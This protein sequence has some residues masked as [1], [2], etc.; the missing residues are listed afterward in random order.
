VVI[1]DVA[2]MRFDDGR[3]VPAGS[4]MNVVRHVRAMGIEPLLLTRIG[5]DAGGRQVLDALSRLGADASGVQVDQSNPTWTGPGG[6]GRP[7]TPDRAWDHLDPHEASRAIETATP[8]LAF[9][10]TTAASSDGSR[11]A[12]REIRNTTGVPFFVDVNLDLPWMHPRDLGPV[13]LGARWLRIQERQLVGLALPDAVGDAD[14]AVAAARSVQQTFALASVVVEAHG[15]PV[16]VVSSQGVSRGS[17]P[18][19][20]LGSRHPTI[21]DAAAAALVAGLACGWS[22]AALLERTIKLVRLLTEAGPPERLDHLFQNAA[23]ADRCHP[24]DEGRRERR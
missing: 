24:S 9:Q 1:G 6:S 19:D 10:T 5:D 7:A 13:L 21:R 3:A 2:P 12:L 4:A 11:S 18:L 8:S 16:T 17:R 20:D 15:L 14:P 22:E 23:A